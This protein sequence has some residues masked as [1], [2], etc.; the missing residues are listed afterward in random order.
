MSPTATS[1]SSAG[2]EITH[3]YS[4]IPPSSCFTPLSLEESLFLPRVTPA[5]LMEMASYPGLAHITRSEL[6]RSYEGIPEA[7]T[8]E[9]DYEADREDECTRTI[10][11]VRRVA[12]SKRARI[13][14][15]LLPNPIANQPEKARAYVGLG[16]GLPSSVTPRITRRTACIG[17]GIILSSPLADN[18]PP[19]ITPPSM[20]CDSLRR[21]FAGIGL[22]LGIIIPQ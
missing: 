7:E 5:E 18:L 6:T 20:H 19:A 3:P 1:S 4:I 22:G 10:E 16:L 9:A 2:P 21:P 13:V 14:R 11:P 17:L 12:N 8:D 15:P